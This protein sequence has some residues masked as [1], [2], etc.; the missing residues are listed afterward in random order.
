MLNTVLTLVSFPAHTLG[1]VKPLLLVAAVIVTAVVVLVLLA[2]TPGSRDGVD[3]AAA[4]EV[5]R[6][7]TGW[8][9]TDA[10]RRRRDGWEVDVHRADGSVVEVNLGPE[11]EL[12][13]LDE[14]L[15]PGGGPAHDELAGEL[16][17]RAIAVAHARGG[18]GDVRSVELE[19]DG[20]IEVDI[21]RADRTVLEVALDP[22]LHVTSVAR[23]ELGDE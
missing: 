12:L 20:S 5:A 21:V 2:F 22:D 18:P 1:S 13:E 8:D 3:A 7:W 19:R 9:K 11:L 15:G 23:E 10:P 4:Q 14:E 17:V 16:R 6:N